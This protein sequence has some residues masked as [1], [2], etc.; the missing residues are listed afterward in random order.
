[1]Y[2][3][4]YICLS[5]LP[6]FQKT[7]NIDIGKP[8]QHSTIRPV[9]SQQQ[10]EVNLRSDA[11]ITHSCKKFSFWLPGAFGQSNSIFDATLKHTCFSTHL[12]TLPIGRWALKCCIGT[13]GYEESL[14]IHWRLDCCRAFYSSDSARLVVIIFY[15]KS[16]F[17]LIPIIFIGNDVE[18]MTQGTQ[19]Y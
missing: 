1:M 14:G 13:L 3:V 15:L 4:P 16:T 18:K 10:K 7:S 8:K 19:F 12:H 9:H 11:W 17:H 6:Y 2:V 5:I